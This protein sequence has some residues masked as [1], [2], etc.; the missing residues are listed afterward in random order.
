M[1]IIKH[2]SSKSANY[3]NAVQYLM[4]EY[5]KLTNRPLH[6]GDGHLIMRSNFIIEGIECDPATFDIECKDLNNQY[7]K[8]QEYNDIK[9][10]H[11]IIS[12]D[13]KDTDTAGLTVEKAQAI[14]VEYAKKN[15]PGHQTIVCTHEDGDNHSGNIHVHIVFNS[16]RKN[17]VERQDFMERKCDSRAGYK[18][19][20]TKDYLKYLKSDLM[21]TC[22]SHGLNQVDL[23][24]KSKNR[25]ISQKA[26]WAQT[27]EA[28]II[29]SSVI[30]RE[31]SVANDEE[32]SL[33]PTAHSS[34]SQQ[35][36]KNRAYTR[37]VEINKLK[38][39]ADALA[40]MQEHGFTSKESIE[41]S[42]KNAHNKAAIAKQKIDAINT[43]ITN[44]NA[45]I[46]YTGAYLVNRK[47][48]ATFLDS[49]DKKVYRKKYKT[50][51]DSYEEAR[52]WLQKQSKE[53]T[54]PSNKFVV[55]TP[56][57]FPRLDVIKKLRDEQIEKRKELRKKYNPL[58]KQ[59]KELQT[60]IK[61]V[62]ALLNEPTH[63]QNIQ[64][65]KSHHQESL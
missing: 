16:V 21:Q 26:Y 7:H 18:H 12:F 39:T 41:A 48:Y 14:G 58:R 57:K 6:D 5:D 40:Y 23:L 51:I 30:P 9:S 47:T 25:R 34:D 4:F 37:K 54:L 28:A 62:E 31:A 20:V 15:F 24:K 55:S 65:S 11:Y 53:G 22:H 49:V 1:A 33:P 63:D 42:L 45:Q 64:K 36:K 17:D 2:L 56:G 59:E 19:H 52:N 13:P 35:T 38:A 60:I 10:H 61:T 29:S 3:R 44:L 46:H 43:D 50:R 27:R 32:S 8:N